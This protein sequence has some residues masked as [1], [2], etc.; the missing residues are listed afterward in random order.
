MTRSDAIIE[1]SDTGKG[2]FYHCF[3]SKEQLVHEV[4]QADLQAIKSGAVRVGR[5]LLGCRRR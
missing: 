3:R 2:Q 4:R 5:T 1:A